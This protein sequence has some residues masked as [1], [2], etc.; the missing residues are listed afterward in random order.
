M[1]K[2]YLE[3]DKDEMIKVY[4]FINRKE[5]F[6]NE[7]ILDEMFK[8][9]IY[10]YGE[11]V[12]F[13]LKNN[14]VVGKAC[15]VLKEVRKLGTAYIHSIEVLESELKKEVVLKNLINK[16]RE[17]SIS[18]GAKE[19]LI[20]VRDESL[21]E[22]FKLLEFKKDYEAIIMELKDRSS[23][24]ETLD[25]ITLREENKEE[26]LRIY[27]DSFNDMPH[28]TSLDNEE[29]EEYIYKSNEE[30]YFYM[31]YANGENIGFFNC[32][33]ENEEG[34]FDIGL[35]KK[36]R[37]IGYGK[38]LLETAIEFLNNKKVKK[39]S[40]IVIERNSVAYNLYNRRGFE[41][42]SVLSYWIVDKKL[43]FKL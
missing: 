34:M 5:K 11:G 27:N 33:I 31:V 26:Y 4:D 19:I 6:N 20:G 1:I 7:N 14:I 15:V 17:K 37:G 3:L 36:Y 16:A 22:T 10:N 38:L 30:N 35:C 41:K 21:L 8:I 42:E 2:S 43:S 24:G 32:E 18:S 39:I 40:L 23:G 9:K 12:F 29:L 28:G 25:L 13:Y